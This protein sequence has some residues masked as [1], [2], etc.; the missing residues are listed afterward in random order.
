[1]SL[2][3]TILLGGAMLAVLLALFGG[4]YAM[5]R[6][7]EFSRKH[8]NRFMRARVILQALALALFLLLLLQGR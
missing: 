6:G 8:S 4:L 1:M 7:A 5:T 2:L 3:I